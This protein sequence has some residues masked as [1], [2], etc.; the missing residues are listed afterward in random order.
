MVFENEPPMT[1][2]LIPSS[3]SC[4]A[5]EM[6]IEFS[7][8]ADAQLKNFN[9]GKANEHNKRAGEWHQIALSLMHTSDIDN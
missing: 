7:N 2:A 4:A 8:R 6:S 9:I 1:E 5:F 3:M